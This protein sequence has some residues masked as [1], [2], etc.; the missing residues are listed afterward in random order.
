[1]KSTE[2]VLDLQAYVDGELDAGRRAEVERL[3]S[4]DTE[5]RQLVEGL[6]ELGRL[7]RDHEPMA[8]VPETREF[9]W[10]QIQRRIKAGEVRPPATGSASHALNWL[11]WLVPAL[12]VAAVVVLVALPR[13]QAHGPEL[14]DATSVTFHSDADGVTIHW[15]D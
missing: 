7:V 3:L 12:G 10:S 11:R 15:L 9:Y 6:Q 1:M 8:V 13:S 5:A 14:A 4:G 2:V